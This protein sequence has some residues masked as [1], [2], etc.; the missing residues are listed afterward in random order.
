VPRVWASLGEIN[1]APILFL[2]IGP[3]PPIDL[4]REPVTEIVR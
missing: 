4:C 2:L 3:V 1:C